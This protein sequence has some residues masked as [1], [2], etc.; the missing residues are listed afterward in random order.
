MLERSFKLSLKTVEEK[1][2]YGYFEGY[3]AVF[4]EKDL[5][6]DIIRKGA[7]KKTLE[8]WQNSGK[9]IPLLYQHKEPIG[10][11][12]KIFEDDYGL[13]VVG[14]INLE[15]EEGRKAYALLKQGAL[16]GLSFGY[17]VVQSRWLKDGTREILEVKLWEVSLVTFPAQE[18]TKIIS[19]KKVVPFQDLPL[20][21]ED[22]PWDADEARWRIAKW[23]SSDGSG[24]KDKIDWN[25]YRKA[26]LWYDEEA[27]NNFGS[28]KL[29]IATV[30]DDRLKAVPRAIF[31]A[32]A[33]LQ[34]A[35][36][37]VDIPESEKEQVKRHL[38]KYYEKMG[39][40]PPWSKEK[41][42]ELDLLM[43][44]GVIDNI[45]LEV[46]EGR[47]LS[48]RNRALLEQIKNAL[49]ALLKLAEP[50]RSTQEGE[51]PQAE[52][53]VDYNALLEQAL[54]NLQEIQQKLGG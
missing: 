3:A 47:V 49:E 41:A 52:E 15:T 6:G 24:D 37:G 21:D 11:I 54:K 10:I 38:E 51:E 22:T 28:Y 25:K 35:R 27:P 1:D 14:E 32:A 50:R 18:K 20:A 19:F 44:L 23:A 26:F 34:G 8:S 4:N 2:G 33:V 36:G 42:Y 45:K 53:E 31:A 40:E 46:K 29:P 13:Y 43:V 16:Q 30:I 5:V 7:F 9:N 39:R 12:T 17:E 48:A